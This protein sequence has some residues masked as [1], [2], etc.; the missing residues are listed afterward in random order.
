MS[1]CPNKIIHFY[2][3]LT[4]P[5]PGRKT[6]MAKDAALY[7]KPISPTRRAIFR[8]LVS[9]FLWHIIQFST[10]PG[11]GDQ[12]EVLIPRSDYK[13]E[14]NLTGILCLFGFA[15]PSSNGLIRGEQ[16]NSFPLSPLHQT[17][18]VSM[19]S[20]LFLPQDTTCTPTLMGSKQFL[21]KRMKLG[22]SQRGMLVA[23]AVS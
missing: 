22:L 20:K 23:G 14:K 8:E 5:S 9:H 10:L 7:M 13:L 18:V 19:K 1:R 3:G 15:L 12:E 4:V 2:K 11:P 21:L 16:N 17:T 6:S